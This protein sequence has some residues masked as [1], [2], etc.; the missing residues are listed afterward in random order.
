MIEAQEEAQKQVRYCVL[1]YALGC[2]TLVDVVVR[3]NIG[4]DTAAG[5]SSD[6]AGADPARSIG[7]WACRTRAHQSCR[8][9]SVSEHQ[10]QQLQ[11]P[12]SAVVRG[13]LDSRLS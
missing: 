10:E 3:S 7:Q 13:P 1:L 9:E 4:P 8:R 11:A 5:G 6:T 12:D 2:Y